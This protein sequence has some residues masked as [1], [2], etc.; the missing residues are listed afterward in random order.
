LEDIPE[1]VLDPRIVSPLGR[2]RA[3]KRVNDNKQTT[4]TTAEA[5]EKVECIN[6]LTIIVFLF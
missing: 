1:N 5:K 6:I 3:K 4:S 2:T